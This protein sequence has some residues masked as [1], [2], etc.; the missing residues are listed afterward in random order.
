MTQDPVSPTPPEEP[1]ETAAHLDVV[2]NSIDDH[3]ILTIDPEGYVTTWNVGAENTKGYTE[4]EIIGRHFS[5]FYT[6]DDQVSGAPM[7]ALAIARETGRHEA[8]G[9]RVHKDGTVFWGNVVIRPIIEPDG[10]VQGFVKVTRDISERLQIETLRETLY[11][12]QQQETR[13]LTEH[14]SELVLRCTGT[15]IM[16]VSPACQ[17]MLGWTPQQFARLGLRALIHP[18]DLAGV[19]PDGGSDRSRWTGRLRRADDAYVWVEASHDLLSLNDEPALERILVVRDID[20]RMTA[21][22]K[23]L[24][25]EA[26]YRLLAEHASDIILR[27]D[28]DLRCRYVS[29]ASLRVLGYSPDEM[30]DLPATE[31]VHPDDVAAFEATL[32]ALLNGHEDVTITFRANH[33]RGHWVWLEA[34][35]RL[36]RDVAGQPVEFVAVLRDVTASQE[37]AAREAEA[38]AQLRSTNERLRRAEAM[39]HIGHWR[40]ELSTRRTTWSDEVFRIHGRPATE[41]PNLQEAI[42]AYHPDDRARVERVL[43]NAIET[44][45]AFSF[46]LRIVQPGGQSRHVATQ[47]EAELGPDGRL[48]ALVG[49]FQDVTERHQLEADLRQAQKLEAVGRVSAGIAHDFNNVLQGIMGGLELILDPGTP[50]GELY[51]FASIAMNSARRGA[52][53]THGLLSYARKQVLQPRRVMLAPV[54]EEMRHLMSQKLPRGIELEIACEPDCPPAEVDPQHLLTALH[55]LALNAIQ[56]MPH[57]GTLRVLAREAGTG[58]V[59]MVSDTGEGMDSATLVQA[60]EPFFTTKGLGGTGLGLSMVQ[61]FARQSGG[62]VQIMSAPGVGT[63]VELRLPALSPLGG[64]TVA[65]ALSDPAALRVLLVD[66]VTDVLVTSAAFLR[67]AGFTVAHRVDGDAALLLLSTGERFDAL[68]T[69]YAMPGMNGIDLILNARAIQPEIPAL[70]ISGFTDLG[71]MQAMPTGVEMLGKPFLREAFVAAVRR[72]ID[73]AVPDVQG[74]E[75]TGRAGGI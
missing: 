19:A 26:R 21:R 33:R 4:A 52:A 67:M 36:V 25:S 71:H 39:S 64:G 53:I 22:L 35:P 55:N 8:D 47:G 11:L 59:I 60:F 44:G 58:V 34:R 56:A 63:Q 75:E 69:D 24:D 13:L 51:E 66:D 32:R 70:L 7:R 74:R 37:V 27:C 20:L 40:Y 62:D 31:R 30:L 15:A 46:E 38:L 73:A 12:S 49:T 54:L 61:G 43:A 45:A 23:L 6:K 72:A 2:L 48:A 17:T 42:A 68:V 14:A 50:P 5:C 10:R 57:G 1:W 65:K 28:L 9:W 16:Y 18:D 29:P 41:P 3:A